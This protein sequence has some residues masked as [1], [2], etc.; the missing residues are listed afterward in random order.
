MYGVPKRTQED[1]LLLATWNLRDFDKPIFGRRSD[2]AI[3]YIAETISHFD[4]IAIQEVYRNLEG[5]Q[6]VMQ[7]L[8]SGWDFL[9]T[10]VGEG[11]AANDERLAFVYDTRKV[12]FAG[13]AGQL[14]LPPVEIDGVLQ[15]PRQFSRTPYLAGFR[16]GWT[17]FVLTTVH[18]LYGG[19]KANLPARVEEIRQL[20]KFLKNRATDPAAWSR[21][22]IVLG[23]FNI[24]NRDDI[25]MR[26]LLDEGFV[27]P[28]ELQ[29]V[30]GTNVPKNKY[31]DQIAFRVR[32]DR[33]NTTGRAGVFDIFETVYRDEDE[34][35]Y[36][37]EMEPR[38]F[39]TS[40]GEPRENPT[41]YYR[42]YWRTHQIS[43]HLPM[44]VE[45]RINYTEPFLER[46]LEDAKH[47][48]K[49]EVVVPLI[50][51]R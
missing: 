4:L 51:I 42:T 12:R 21:N 39:T 47:T 37:P 48:R 38:Y 15:N 33:L 17:D 1:T 36:I 29:R 23:D 28:P 5:L 25:T 11:E 3:H 16:S 6:R 34:Q 26:A 50:P 41:Q 13:L 22:V 30:P 46:L 2:E 14:V 43:D 31:Y 35:L 44:W 27:I 49:E 32:E 40:D 18:I 8:G 9:V 45:L 24:F 10:D 20:A 19:S 7:L